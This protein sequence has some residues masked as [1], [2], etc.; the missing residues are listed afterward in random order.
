[1]TAPKL[2]AAGFAF[3]FMLLLRAFYIPAAGFD[4]PDFFWHIAYGQWILA[5]HALPAGDIFSWTMPGKP[6]L[7]TQWLGEVLMAIAYD[8]GGLSGTLLLSVLPAGIAIGF[9]FLSARQYTHPAVAMTIAGL[10]SVTL[11]LAPMRPQMFSFAL[12]AVAMWLCVSCLDTRKTAYLLGFPPLIALWV[13]LHG[14]FVV[15]LVLLALMTV[16][17]ACEALLSGKNTRSRLE[18]FKEGYAAARLPGLILLLSIAATGLNPYG[19]SALANVFLIG[20]LESAKVIS[21]WQTV[22]LTGKMGGFYLLMLIPYLGTLII[23]GE[24]PRLTLGLIGAVFLVFGYL[25][26]RQVM[27]CA[28]VMAP[29]IAE[30]VGKT[31]NYRKMLLRMRNPSAPLGFGLALAFLIGLCFMNLERFNESALAAR[32]SRYPVAATEFI[33]SRNLTARVLS[34]TVEAS[35]LIHQGVPVFIDGRMDLYGDDFFF[36]WRAALEGKPSWK[37]FLDRHTP[38]ALLLENDAALRQLALASGTWKL[39]HVDQKYSVLVPDS[40]PPANQ[41]DAP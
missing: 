38:S 11:L 26:N 29:V 23:A 28:A 24:R 13:N 3:L 9:S 21:E 39:A 14:G 41:K 8:S 36:A 12:L 18:A 34:D 37:S 1:L 7:M 20:S 16:G 15:G 5:H 40:L 17:L 22:D 25:A 10:C 35:W 19:F 27:M 31:E 32:S 30:I 4:D 6:Y 33:Q 2:T